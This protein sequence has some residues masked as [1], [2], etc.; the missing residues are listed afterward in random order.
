MGN[1][2]GHSVRSVSGRNAT[3][4]LCLRNTIFRIFRRYAPWISL[5]LLA[6]IGGKMAYESL[7][8]AKDDIKDV[9]WIWNLGNIVVLAI[10]TSID[11]L[12]TGV[13]F[14][15]YPGKVWMGVGIIAI[16]SLLFSIAGYMIGMIFGKRFKVNV[17]LIGGLILIGIGLKIWIEGIWLA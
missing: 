2:D 16:G 3:D 10:A 5:A 14:I 7:H 17:E 4:R 1:G 6:Y 11:A 12:A 15:P 9:E 8:P 13:I